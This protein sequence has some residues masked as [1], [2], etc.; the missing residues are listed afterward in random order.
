MVAFIALASAYFLWCCTLC[1]RIVEVI[2]AWRFRS[3]TPFLP[4]G[5]EIVLR[6]LCLFIYMTYENHAAYLSLR[7]FAR[8]CCCSRKAFGIAAATSIG[9]TGKGAG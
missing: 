2:K 1:A 7:V 3:G 5:S 9:S 8:C 4:F 6:V